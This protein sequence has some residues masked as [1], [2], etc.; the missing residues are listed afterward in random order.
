M[1]APLRLKLLVTGLVFKALL[2]KFR[3]ELLQ[4]FAAFTGH[5]LFLLFEQAALFLLPVSQSCFILVLQGLCLL[6][7]LHGL[8]QFGLDFLP[9]LFND[10]QYRLVEEAFQ[11]PH[12]DQE[13]DNLKGEGRPVE[14]Q[15]D[16]PI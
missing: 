3:I 6:L 15:K 4:A 5:L 2:F 10:G 8:G 13:I 16:S 7:S 11:Q 14:F 1:A 9:S 12:Q